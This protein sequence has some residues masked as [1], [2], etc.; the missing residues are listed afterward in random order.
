[1]RKSI[2]RPASDY[3]RQSA[4]KR[5][6]GNCAGCFHCGESRP[7]ALIPN[8]T[9]RIC[10]K[11]QRRNRGQSEV[12]QHHVAGRNNHAVTIPVPVN[13]H[14]DFFSGDQNSWPSKTLRNPQRSPLLAAAACIRGFLAVMRYL[15]DEILGWIAPELERLDTA[16]CEK[17]G[18]QWWRS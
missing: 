18:A 15:I 10:A 14:R 1:M 13:D 5:R 7:A 12:D 4:A 16:L 17:L 6:L 9:P 8:T 11:C 2:S 3:G